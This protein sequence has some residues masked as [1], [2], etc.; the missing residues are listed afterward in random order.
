M[1]S[2]IEEKLDLIRSEASQAVMYPHFAVAIE[3][4]KE[5]I[6]DKPGDANVWIALMEREY[7]TWYFITQPVVESRN[8]NPLVAQ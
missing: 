6:A 1:Y 3:R 8:D 2:I 4:I 7:G 5:A